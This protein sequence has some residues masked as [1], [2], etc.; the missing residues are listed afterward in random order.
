[1]A[2]I[3]PVFLRRTVSNVITVNETLQHPASKKIDAIEHWPCL[4]L[5][6]LGKLSQL[7]Q[8]SRRCSYPDYLG[9]EISDQKPWSPHGLAMSPWVSPK[10][11]PKI[12]KNFIRRP[13]IYL[14]CIYLFIMY[15]SIY[16]QYVSM[17]LSAHL[18]L[19]LSLYLSLMYTYLYIYIYIH[20]YMIYI[21]I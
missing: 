5:K 15:L 4:E 21:Y 6:V 17:Y 2:H 18:S 13:S 14:S 11:G 10:R 1:M 19:S 8:H 16:A 12:W 3:D 20:M 7:D 9:I